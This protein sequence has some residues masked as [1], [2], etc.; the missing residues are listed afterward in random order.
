MFA[1]FQRDGT[2][3]EGTVNPTTNGQDTPSTVQRYLHNLQK[4]QTQTNCGGHVPDVPRVPDPRSLV[5]KRLLDISPI[6]FRTA[7]ELHSDPGNG[8][9][10]E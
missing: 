6:L 7:F 3:D 10:T 8:H 2:A 9:K 4:K 5:Q 1:Y